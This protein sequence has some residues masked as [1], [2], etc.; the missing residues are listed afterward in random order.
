MKGGGRSIA[1]VAGSIMREFLALLPDFAGL[2]G[3]VLVS[4]GAWMV[5][6]PAGFIVGGMLLL[7]GSIFASRAR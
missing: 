3:A 6:H 5:Y 2:A 1:F 4:R 7:A